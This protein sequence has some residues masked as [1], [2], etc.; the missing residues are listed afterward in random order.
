MSTKGGKNAI[1]LRCNPENPFSYQPKPHPVHYMKNLVAFALRWF[2]T[3]LAPK[4]VIEVLATPAPVI[5][6][7]EESDS[8]CPICTQPFLI[9]AVAFAIPLG[10]IT[11]P[12]PESYIFDIIDDDEAKI[13]VVLICGKSTCIDTRAKRLLAHGKMRRQGLIGLMTMKAQCKRQT[14]RLTLPPGTPTTPTQPKTE[15]A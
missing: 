11:D 1:V 3:Q 4:P 13:P 7:G 14:Q 12:P 10:D 5:P 6:K 15:A 8:V 2:R 9:D